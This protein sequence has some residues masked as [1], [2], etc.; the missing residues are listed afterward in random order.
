[1]RKIFLIYVLFSLFFLVSFAFIARISASWE[2]HSHSTSSIYSHQQLDKPGYTRPWRTGAWER[3]PV[4]GFGAL[5]LFLA[6][7]AA[8]ATILIVSNGQEVSTWAVQPTVLLAVVSAVGTAALA[9]TQAE[10]AV[11]FW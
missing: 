9:F 8:S 2:M 6:T 1:M 7:I 11:V 10:G 4:L 3:F 5:T